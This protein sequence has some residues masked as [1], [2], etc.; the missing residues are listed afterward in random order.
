M[1]SY[2]AFEQELLKKITEQLGDRAQ[3]VLRDIVRNN[4]T[5][6]RVLT[7]ETEGVYASPAYQMDNLYALRDSG[8][9]IDAITEQIV[10]QWSETSAMTDTL[11]KV[12]ESGSFAK[13]R[14]FLKLVNRSMNEERLK[15]M[16]FLPFLDLAAVLYIEL[17]K[18]ADGGMTC[19]VTKSMLKAWG[20]P[21]RELFATALRNTRNAKPRVIRPLVEMTAEMSGKDPEAFPEAWEARD[22]LTV[23]TNKGAY[24][25]AAAILYPDTP[26]ELRKRFPG[27]LF[28]IP[29]SIHELILVPAEE[30]EREEL[31]E[32]LRQ[33]NDAVLSPAEI[34]GTEVYFFDRES[35]E[36]MN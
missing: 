18:N 10:R 30:R 3:A 24:F 20:I 27:D 31:T 4:H 19:D 9:A 12:T 2:Q 22:V 32:M 26:D 1:E 17:Q 33:V 15:D 11:M 29:S 16:P 23:M 36:F 13:E 5:A 7:I 25:G 21:E 6:V 28:V 34:L 14:V 8:A 35:G